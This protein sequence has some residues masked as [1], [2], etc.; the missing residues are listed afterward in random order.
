MLEVHDKPFEW[1]TLH[2]VGHAV[3]LPAYERYAFRLRDFVR[4][5]LAR[6]GD[7]AR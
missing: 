7:E 3:P 5:H 2:A 1:I 6:D 4:E